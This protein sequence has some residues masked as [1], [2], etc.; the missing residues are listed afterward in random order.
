MITQ[1]P[2]DV[3][4]S[5]GQKAYLTCVAS[6]GV[7]Y[8]WYKDNM[9]YAMGKTTGRLELYPVSPSHEGEY[10]CEVVNDS[11]KERSKRARVTVGTYVIHMLHLSQYCYQVYMYSW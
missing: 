1:H 2:S 11:G 3:R 10:Y 6:G 7:M 4:G 8:D 5:V 9:L